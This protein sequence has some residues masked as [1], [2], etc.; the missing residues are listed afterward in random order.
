MPLDALVRRLLRGPDA[1]AALR[2]DRERTAAAA[3]S[4]RTREAETS[5]PYRRGDGVLMGTTMLSGARSAE[6]RLPRKL[7]LG[8][9][10]HIVGATGTGKTTAM[11]AWAAQDV[12]SPGVVS[13]NLDY[14]GDFAKNLTEVVIPWAAVKL[15]VEGGT[16]LLENLR[17][18][19]PWSGRRIP[20]LHLTSPGGSVSR[21]AV[22]LT[23]LFVATVGA[24]ELGHR[25]LSAFVPAVKLM[26]KTAVPFA[27]LPEVFSLPGLRAALL[28]AAED[29]ELT[30]YFE[31]R[32]P[33]DAREGVVFSI[34]SRLDRFL[35]DDTTKL[36]LFGP[37][38]FDAATWLESGTTVCDFGGGLRSHRVFWASFVQHAVL[39]AVLSRPTRRTSPR[40]L[41]RID[42]VQM[43]IP[44]AAQAE[45][46]DDALCLMRSR[47]ASLQ[48][49][50]QHAGQL[51]AYPSLLSS[52]RAN[53]G[54]M[55]AF[56]I[57]KESAEATSCVVPEGLP[58]GVDGGGL[59]ES[60]I[61]EAWVRALSSLPDRT[62]L[63][64][65]PTLA[66][67]SIPVRA[68]VLDLEALAREVPE[69]VRA[70]GRDGTDGFAPEELAARE[71]K[72][73]RVALELSATREPNAAALARF[74]E[75]EPD[76]RAPGRRPRRGRPTE[77]EP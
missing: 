59:T 63:L 69:P 28:V 15:P 74:A 17:V 56:R 49:A 25:Q 51:A 20:S 75:P 32:F 5:A 10:S 50:H 31:N 40:V 41:I 42:E 27:L 12:A 6:V 24:G 64:R 3:E 18:W 4:E 52:L 53:V 29:P 38:G 22:A 71:E 57:P 70:L 73:R 48:I 23:D 35:A 11:T 9:S 30:S 72:W 61:R 46:L 16:A 44:T 37:H 13:V 1:E 14:K 39:E 54:M 45:E 21:R 33:A 55:A 2:S 77:I 66:P 19:A 67:S 62:F 7:A 58:P 60:Q 43:A 36:A 47:R 8:L 34:L 76:A 65:A 26:M 68:P